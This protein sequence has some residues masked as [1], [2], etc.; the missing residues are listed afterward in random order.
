MNQTYEPPSSSQSPSGPEPATGNNFD[1][2]ADA[3]APLRQVGDELYDYLYETAHRVTKNRGSKT[4]TEADIIEARRALLIRP[5]RSGPIIATQ[6]GAKLGILTGGLI[7][8]AGMNLWATD[9]GPALGMVSAGLLLAIACW[10]IEVLIQR[11]M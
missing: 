5:R 10:A 9:T 3:I 6:I 1:L 8:G 2:A 4:I 11:S 7:A